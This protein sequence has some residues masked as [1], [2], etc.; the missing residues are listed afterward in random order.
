[1]CKRYD[2]WMGSN[3]NVTWELCQATMWLYELCHVL[4]S[5]VSVLLYYWIL[6]CMRWDRLTLIL[7][8][9]FVLFFVLFPYPTLPHWYYSFL[10]RGTG[11]L[12]VCACS[13]SFKK[14]LLLIVIWGSWIRLRVSFFLIFLLT[15]P[16][17]VIT[18]LFYLVVLYFVFMFS[19]VSS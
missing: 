9:R 2:K 10:T 3:N 1:M 5:S 12:P 7:R 6:I 19:L 16:L 8:R 17:L 11:V 4:S 15:F 14:K 18:S 13:E